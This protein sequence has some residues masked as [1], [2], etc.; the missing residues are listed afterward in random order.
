MMATFRGWVGR[1]GASL[2]VAGTLLGQADGEAER[3]LA[4]EILADPDMPLVLEMARALLKTGLTAGSGYGEVWIRDLNTFIELSLQVNPA[5]DIRAAL[6]TFFKFQEPNGDVPDGYI[7]KDKAAV[8]YRYR[9]STLAPDL[10]AHKNTVE[11]DQESSL[12]QAVARYVRLTGDR[13]VLAEPVAG[14]PVL[15][16]LELALDYLL[17][18]RFDAERGLLWGATTADWGDVQ[19]EHEWG[20]E[21]DVASHRACDIYDNA[22]AVVA[23]D[24]LIPLLAGQ[25]ERQKRWQSRRAELARNIRRH[26]WD[27]DRGKFIPHV[28][29]AGSPFPADFDENAV[30]FHGGTAVAMEAGLLS[31]E[32]I[33]AALA[34][35]RANVKAAGA[36]SVGL[37]IYPPYPTGFFKNAHLGPYSYQNGGDWCWFGGRLIRQLLAN[38]L[39]RE[40]YDELKPMI[41]R[42]K[43]HG[44]FFEWWSLDNQPRGSKQYRGSAGVLG[45]A[46]Q[47]LHEWARRGE[48]TEND[49]RR[50]DQGA[51]RP[52]V[53]SR[54]MAAGDD[55]LPPLPEGQR[56]QLVWND[57]F[58]GTEIDPKKWDVMGDWKRR[59]GFWVKEDAFLDGQGH[60]VLRTKKDGDRYTSGAVR[61]LGRFEHAFGYWVARCRLPTQPGHWPAFWLM[62]HGVNNVGEDGRDGTEIDIMEVPWRDGTVTMNLHWDG[63]GRQHKS[64]GTKLVRPEI[65]SGFHTYALHWTDQEYVFYLDGRELWRSAAGGVSRVPSYLKLTEEIGPWGGD[66]T[67]ASL[68][69][70]FEVDYVRVY[71]AVP[72]DPSSG[73]GRNDADP[74]RRGK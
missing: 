11:T 7:P 9:R 39:V 36:S 55:P 37:T 31:Q 62:A 47:Q 69:D 44:D 64:A 35:M 22:L 30:W 73:D 28:Y 49:R 14:K 2:C 41:R 48:H 17:T 43:Q 27:K 50:P 18:E 52:E 6:L 38:G 54:P 65:L 23:M 21:L 53:D 67:R 60:L 26:L 59:D 74:N 33:A 58:A 4:A 24:E 66:I 63:Y 12:V 45:I 42:V 61:T 57:E 68:P 13:S 19:P 71:D 46:I 32:E 20:V 70:S 5:A 1:W 40:A 34:S 10:L 56:W 72:A 3:E 25:P 16:R 15:E 51:S 29:L 8:N